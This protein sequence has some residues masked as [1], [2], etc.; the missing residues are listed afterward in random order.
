MYSSP[1]EVQ[2]VFRLKT[3]AIKKLTNEI[4][5][6]EKQL[7]LQLECMGNSMSNRPIVGI[8]WMNFGKK[9]SLNIR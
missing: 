1:Y 9:F 4:N 8:F 3:R 2:A 7:I 6:N 5:S